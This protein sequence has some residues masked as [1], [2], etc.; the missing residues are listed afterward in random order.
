VASKHAST[1]NSGAE[2]AIKLGQTNRNP[3]NIPSSGHMLLIGNSEEEGE[4]GFAFSP[5]QPQRPEKGERRE[6]M[7]KLFCL[8][9]SEKV[10]A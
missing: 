1:H 4:G 7:V 3:G 8:C 5:T 2:K 10:S 6:Q 9:A